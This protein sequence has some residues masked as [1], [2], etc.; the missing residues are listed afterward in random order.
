MVQCLYIRTTTNKSTTYVYV[1]EVPFNKKINSIVTNHKSSIP[2][3]NIIH[4]YQ[5]TVYIINLS[6]TNL[7]ASLLT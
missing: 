3:S 5:I 6:L 2:T 1:K 7:L 4:H